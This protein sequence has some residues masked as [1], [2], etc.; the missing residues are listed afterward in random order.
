M[1]IFSDGMKVSINQRI[2]GNQ[3]KGS[4]IKEVL[5]KLTFWT[6]PFPPCPTSSA[7]QTP[8]PSPPPHSDFRTV[9]IAPKNVRNAKY[10]YCNPDA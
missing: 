5:A 9:R 6:P 10:N 7:W 1:S 2:E 3:V 4:S 8:P